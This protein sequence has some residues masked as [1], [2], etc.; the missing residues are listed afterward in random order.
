MTAEKITKQQVQHLLLPRK[1]DAEKRD[2]GHLLL[3]GGSYGM[4]GA[5]SMA[6]GAALRSGAG[7]V[8]ILAPRCGYTILQSQVPEAMILPSSD[9][10]YLEILP[11]LDF[12]EQVAVGPGLGR[13]EAT[14]TFI[15]LLLRMDKPMLIDADA[16][17]IISVQHWQPRIPKGSLLTPNLREFDRLFPTEKNKDEY[18]QILREKAAELNC[19][20]LLKGAGTQVAFPDG[21]VYVNT[22]GN[23]GMAK[24][25]SGDVLTGIIAGLWSR[26]NSL[27]HAVVAGVYLHGLAGDIAASKFHMESMLPTDLVACLPDAFRQLDER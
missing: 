4:I 17:N 24:G 7:L 12:F 27:E 9:D 8:T 13:H 23:P 10:A 25:G 18:P 19:Y 1:K 26:L 2:F 11:G 5:V 6:A 20:I 21:R 16:L 15:D 14:A 22:T 3:I